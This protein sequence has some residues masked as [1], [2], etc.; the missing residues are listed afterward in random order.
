MRIE[1]S[2]LAGTHL[3]N[4]ALHAL[5]VTDPQTDAL[6]AEYLT[7]AQRIKADL[8]APGLVDLMHEIEMLR[9]TYVRGD[10]SGGEA[11]ADRAF[12]LVEAM[13]ARVDSICGVS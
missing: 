12:A 6:H 11:A 3:M 1:A 9:P 10:W 7:G 8:L 2:M 13:Q 4:M 5:G